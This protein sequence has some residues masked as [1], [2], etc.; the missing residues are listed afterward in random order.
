MKKVL[1]F[2]RADE[3]NVIAEALRALG[4]TYTTGLG[5]AVDDVQY[6]GDHRLA[7]LTHGKNTYHVPVANILL[8]RVQEES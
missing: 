8:V 4:V 7:T 5:F 6:S 1:V 2:F 3:R